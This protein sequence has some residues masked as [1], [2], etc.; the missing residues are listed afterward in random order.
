MYI[1]VTYPNARSNETL[2][3]SAVVDRLESLGEVDWN[4]SDEQLSRDELRD[5][6][7]GVDVCVTGWGTHEL[8]E[9]VLGEAGSLELVAHVGGSV[10]SIA[11]PALYDREIP[12]CS[13]NHVMAPFVAEGILSYVLSSFRSVID[14]DAAVKRGEWP[15][16]A[17]DPTD[18]LYG[19]TVGFVGLG[20]VGRTL[21]ELLEPFDVTVDVYDPYISSDDLAPFDF[22]TRA[23]LESTLEGADVVSIHASK[24][25]ETLHMIDTDRL[26]SLPDGCLLVNAARGAI[27]DEDALVDELETGR[28]S[29]ALDVYEEEPLPEDHPLRDIENVVLGPHVAGNPCRRHLADAVVTEVERFDRGDPLQHTVPRERYEMMTRDWLSA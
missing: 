14:F 22:A 28:I 9:Y 21:L 26:A 1:L 3:P 6:L 2:Y 29:A 4:D 27:V 5:R 16:K 12:V 11:S 23:D 10:A 7:E 19:A 25:P 13:A 8:S 15:S 17:G 24:T 20:T 18:S